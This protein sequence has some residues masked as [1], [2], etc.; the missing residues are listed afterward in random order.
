[1]RGEKPTLE[2][3]RRETAMQ[4]AT[5]IAVCN[6]LDP[7]ETLR[8]AAKVEAYLREGK[9]PRGRRPPVLKMVRKSQPTDFQGA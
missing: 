6:D 5:E 3:Q 2:E 9:T 8:Y 1:V 7:D 4:L